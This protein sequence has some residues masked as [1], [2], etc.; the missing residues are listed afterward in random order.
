MAPVPDL[1][2]IHS[3]FIGRSFP[4]GDQLPR[5]ARCSVSGQ[6]HN[7][8]IPLAHD[9]PCLG[10]SWSS[11]SVRSCLPLRQR[12]FSS[13]GDTGSVTTDALADRSALSRLWDWVNARMRWTKFQQMLLA[14]IIL[15][16]AVCGARGMVLAKEKLWSE[17]G[18]DEQTFDNSSGE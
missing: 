14:V 2:A 16:V 17:L 10:T 15:L 4:G 1:L 9:T 18:M 6:T 5:W 7:S 11:Y 8:N 13:D 3:R 12:P